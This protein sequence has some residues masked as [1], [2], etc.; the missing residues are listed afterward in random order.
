M[1]TKIAFAVVLS[2]LFVA[3]PSA[4]PKG[5]P[6]PA[7]LT[8]TVG[9]SE[10]VQDLA[11]LGDADTCLITASNLPLATYKIVVTDS[12]G[13]IFA[14]DEPPNF[15]VTIYPPDCA[16]GLTISLFTLGKGGALTPVTVTITNNA[17]GVV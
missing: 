12:C 8:L 6:A 15:N 4:T 17:S 10:P 9:C 14:S 1:K 11:G 7:A 13:F 5:K 16:S 2:V 3:V